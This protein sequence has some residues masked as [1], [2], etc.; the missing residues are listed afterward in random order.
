MIDKSKAS[1][2]ATD[3]LAETKP[4]DTEPLSVAVNEISRT[5]DYWVIPWNSAK[6]EKTQDDRDF[7]VGCSAI[8]VDAKSGA[9]RYMSLA[10]EQA[11]WAAEDASAD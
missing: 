10:E 7:L 4:V 3:F 1:K 9:C 2:L 6:F 8:A 11:L 5:D